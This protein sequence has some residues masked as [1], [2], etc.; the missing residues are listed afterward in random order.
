MAF[1]PARMGQTRVAVKD[2]NMNWLPLVSRAEQA[3]STALT[4]A[5]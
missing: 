2:Q 5:R 4:C 3:D 1:A